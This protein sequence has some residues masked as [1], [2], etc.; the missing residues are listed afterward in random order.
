MYGGPAEIRT[1]D[2]RC[3]GYLPFDLEYEP[4]SASSEPAQTKKTILDRSALPS[5]WDSYTILT[6]LIP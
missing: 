4:I 2:L 1:H 6:L 5:I 3:E